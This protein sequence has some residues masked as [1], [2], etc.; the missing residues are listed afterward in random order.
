VASRDG[1]KYMVEILINFTHEVTNPITKD[2][3]GG[4]WKKLGLH[5]VIMPFRLMEEIFKLLGVYAEEPIFQKV[6]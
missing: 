5:R 6:V 3:D 4:E 1:K 2:E